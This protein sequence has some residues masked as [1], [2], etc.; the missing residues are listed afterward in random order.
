MPS[1]LNHA[2]SFRS[3]RQEAYDSHNFSNALTHLSITEKIFA[4]ASFDLGFY[5]AQGPAIIVIPIL[6]LV[7]I[8]FF[9]SLLWIYRDAVKPEK[10]GILAV[11]FLLSAWPLSLLWWFWLRP[12]ISSKNENV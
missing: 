4:P 7:L 12:A 6:A 5:K 1:P 11:L 10:N 9:Y 2:A 3:F 8:V